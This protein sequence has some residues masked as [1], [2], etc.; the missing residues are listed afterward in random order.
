MIHDAKFDTKDDSIIQNSSQEL[1]MSSMYD[2]VLTALII[3]LVSWKFE[4]NSGMTKHVDSWC[5]IW[6]Q[7][8]SNPSKL[9]SGTI[10]ILQVWLCSWWTSI[11]AR[12]L[13]IGIQLKIWHMIVICDVKFDIKYDQILQN[14]IREPSMS[15]MYDCVLD[16]LLFMLGS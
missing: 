15:S 5:Q 10:N 9:L 16:E 1:S 8:Q 3:M 12:K 7:R 2:C 4:Y 11:H 13:K 6:Y 14:S